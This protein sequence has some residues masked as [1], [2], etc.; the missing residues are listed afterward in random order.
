MP[1]SSRLAAPLGLAL[2]ALTLPPCAPAV[3]EAGD[4]TLKVSP[5]FARGHQGAAGRTS[6][7]SVPVDASLGIDRVTLSLRLP[8]LAVSG[9]G[10]FLPRIGTLGSA[11]T[12]GGGRSGLGDIRLGAAVAVLEHQTS[13][14][15]NYLDLGVKTR[16]PTATDASLGTTQFEHMLLLDGGIALPGGLALDLTLGRR[17]VPVPRRGRGERDYWTGF[18]S[19]SLD[20]GEGWRAG[21]MASGQDRLPDIATPIIEAGAFLERDLSPA[22]TLGL[23]AWHGMTRESDSFSLGLRIAYRFQGRHGRLGE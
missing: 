23:S 13:H 12:D 11:G 2:L 9:P 7:V 20:F 3:A 8:Y 5:E 6:A 1:G 14:G 22:L 17:V 19:L 4:L 16:L 18:A 10:G 15:D 21:V